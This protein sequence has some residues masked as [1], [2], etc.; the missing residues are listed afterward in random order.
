MSLQDQDRQI[1]AAAKKR[2]Y[3]MMAEEAP[4][5]DVLD[6]LV[7]VVE[8]VSHTNVRASILLLDEDRKHLRHGAA[9]SLPDAYNASIDGLSIGPEAGS[10]G[11]A[12]YH[13]RDVVVFDIAKDPLWANYR[14]LALPHGLRAC[15]STPIHDSD[16]NVLG[17]F[18]NYYP[19]VSD[20]SPVDRELTDM[21][22]HTAAIAIEEDRKRRAASSHARVLGTTTL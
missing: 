10:C 6:E 7:R 14:E 9:P 11:T 21:V 4:L 1:V 15:W 19:V 17:T 16:G 5:R 18:A 13:D 12:A 8:Q 2:I 22:T 3:R 20:P